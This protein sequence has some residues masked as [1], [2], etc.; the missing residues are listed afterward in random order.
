MEKILARVQKLLNLAG[1]NPN[2]AEASAAIEKAHAILAE[3]NLSLAHVQAHG[4]KVEQ[5]DRGKNDTATNFSEKYYGWIWYAVAD[6]NFCRSF[7]FRPNPKRRETTYTV[8]GR[9]INILVAS[10]MAMYLCQTMRRLANEEAKRAGRTD[11]AFKN[12]FLAGCANRL[13]IRLRAMKAQETS[14]ASENVS[15]ALTIWSGSE[16]E[17]NDRFIEKVMGIKLLTRKSHRNGKLDVSGFGAGSRAADRVS[18]DQQIG[19]K[20][21]SARQIA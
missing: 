5:G 6:L 12:A 13:C 16:A 18:L 9:E 7:Q 3:H 1:N 14:T 8:V 15:A 4:D 11:H 17:E 10:Q 21:D 19:A 2:E 20:G